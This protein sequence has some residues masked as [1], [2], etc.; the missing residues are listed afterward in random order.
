M[1]PL[2]H[3][4][5]ARHADRY[6]I[7]SPQGVPE[8]LRIVDALARCANPA[9]MAQTSAAVARPPA[10]LPSP[11]AVLELLKPI[12][13]FAPM[14]AYLCGAVSAG[15]PLGWSWAMALAGAVL[16]GPLVCATSQAVNDWYDREVDAIN[17]PNR[18]IPS[19]RIPGTWGLKIAIIWTVLS[20]VVAAL[21]GLWVLVGACVGLALAWAYS[22]PP[23][24]LKRS[25]WTGPAAVALSYEGVAWFTGAA[26]MSGTLPHTDSIILA[27]LYSLAAFGMMTLNDFKAVEGDRVMGIRSLPVVLGLQR[28]VWLACAV[29]AIPQMVVVG[30]LFAW[31]APVSASVV[32][33]LIM[34]QLLMMTRLVTD[35]AKYAPWYN[36]TGIGPCVLGMMVAAVAIMP[37]AGG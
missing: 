1:R 16:A 23:W 37:S 34:I 27:G 4:L 2:S 11:K 17:E 28:A 33:G 7:A 22:A 14:W 30:L 12:T 8:R 18:P 36:A 19:G 32:A 3:P 9:A 20:L 5:D 13:W 15:Q 21:L 26:A 10:A 29:M 24:R 25:G 35:P 31:G 6:H